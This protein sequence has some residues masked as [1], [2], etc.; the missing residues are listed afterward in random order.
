M[1]KAFSLVELVFVMVIL[2]ILAS[3]IIP[4]FSAKK[5][6]ADIATIKI[7]IAAIRAGIRDYTT[8]QII[9]GKTQVSWRP[10]LANYASSTWDTVNPSEN[11]SIY[12]LSLESRFETKELF[13]VVLPKG[14][15]IKGANNKNEKGLSRFN[16]AGGTTFSG[17]YFVRF[18]KETVRFDYCSKTTNA[19]SGSICGSRDSPDANL[20]GKL[21]C[22]GDKC[23]LLGEEQ[24]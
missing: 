1:K 12:P 9:S 4:S 18:G 14:Y 11:Q 17:R 10:F 15:H 2:E 7:Q 13:S 21:Y 5:Q 23:G 22:T 8:S 20:T 19:A 6:D 3:F 24:I 16:D